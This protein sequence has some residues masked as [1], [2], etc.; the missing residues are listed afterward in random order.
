MSVF[1]DSAALYAVLDAD[2]DNHAA[3]K[4]VWI[5]LLNRRE[6]LVCSNYILVESFAL[7]Q[8]RLGMEAA[9]A[10]QEDIVPVLSIYWVD[11]Y[12]HQ[13]SVSAMLTAGQ[14]QLSLVDCVSFECMRRLGIRTAFTF[15]RH[16]AEQG[17]Q[18]IP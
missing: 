17:F 4:G 8:H 5:D 10:L 6:E 9:R 16:F 14:R 15:D 11:Q 1:I 7:V 3:A 18:C 12:T 2:D 13:A